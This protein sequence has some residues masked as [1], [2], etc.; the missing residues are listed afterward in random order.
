M[1]LSLAVGN[2]NRQDDTFELTTCYI[3]Q[4]VPTHKVKAVHVTRL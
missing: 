1:V 4:A 3:I 2:C